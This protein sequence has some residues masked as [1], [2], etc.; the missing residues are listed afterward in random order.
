MV[1]GT[2]TR[3][4]LPSLFSH[5]MGKSEG[6][7]KEII[8]HVY[9]YLKDNGS[10]KRSLI[11]KDLG[12]INLRKSQVHTALKALFFQK[13]VSRIRRGVYMAGRIIKDSGGTHG[14]GISSGGH[15]HDRV[16]KLLHTHPR[17][18]NIQGYISVRDWGSIPECFPGKN[19]FV[20]QRDL[21]TYEGSYIKLLRQKN[22]LQFWFANKRPAFLRHDILPLMGILDEI[23][24]DYD[25]RG[26]TWIQQL[27]FRNQSDEIVYDLK[28]N[29][30]GEKIIEGYIGRVYEEED[31]T[32]KKEIRH[33]GGP[34]RR[35]EIVN[36]IN[37]LNTTMSQVEAVAVIQSGVESISNKMTLVHK[38]ISRKYESLF[39]FTND[40]QLNYETQ[41]IGDRLISVKS[42]MLTYNSSLDKLHFKISDAV[43]M[44]RSY[45]KSGGSIQVLRM[46]FK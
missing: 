38:D 32:I 8:E 25:I 12:K 20:Y 13:R 24:E 1:G 33:Y 5:G 14:Q 6:G 35:S 43:G 30:I 15:S 10:R 2:S 17:I 34:Y 26:T 18:H 22:K 23:L 41:E 46:D 27:E 37:G 16:F 19:Y 40:A 31:G 3:P 7:E 44:W 11:I 28:D 21:D 42:K 4:P 29:P 36:M 39:D 9:D 45:E